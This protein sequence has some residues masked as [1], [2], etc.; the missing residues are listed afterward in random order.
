VDEQRLALEASK[1]QVMTYTGSRWLDV[2]IVLANVLIMVVNGLVRPTITYAYFWLYAAVKWAQY[3][4]FSK[5][6]ATPDAIL[7]LWQA[8]DQAVFG[9]VI[10]FWF[11]S[12]TLKWMKERYR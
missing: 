5:T 8:E 7:V 9:A 6:L 10:G 12:R 1:P 4:V 2:P 3:Q 11:G